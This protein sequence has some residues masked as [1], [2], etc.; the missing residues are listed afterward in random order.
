MACSMNHF[1]IQNQN[2]G[3]DDFSHIIPWI[4]HHI[5]KNDIQFIFVG[6]VPKQL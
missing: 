6:G 1:D 2:N 3:I 4:E 5:K